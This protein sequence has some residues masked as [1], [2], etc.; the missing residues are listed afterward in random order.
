MSNKINSDI[1]LGLPSMPMTQNRELHD[2]LTIVYTAI[3]ILQRELSA[4][5]TRIKSL[6]DYNVAHP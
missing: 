4:A 1:N 5:K 2:E 6:E 3:Q